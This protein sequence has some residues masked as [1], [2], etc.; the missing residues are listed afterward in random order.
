MPSISARPPSQ[1]PLDGGQVLLAVGAGVGGVYM[2]RVERDAADRQRLFQVGYLTV[3][4]SDLD[5]G[6]DGT[7]AVLFV[8]KYARRHKKERSPS[9]EPSVNLPFSASCCAVTPTS[10]SG[11]RCPLNGR[12]L[13]APAH[14]PSGAEATWSRNFFYHRDHSPLLIGNQRGTVGEHAVGLVGLV[15]SFRPVEIRF[16]ALGRSRRHETLFDRAKPTHET[17]ET[18][19]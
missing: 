16:V 11:Y 15:G 12:N 18:H 9:G 17:N 7:T 6:L 13:H 4:R 19:G 14:T 8:G 3:G 10:C 5:G 2:Q 1:A